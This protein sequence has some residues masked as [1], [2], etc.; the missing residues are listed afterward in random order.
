MIEKERALQILEAGLITS[1]ADQTE[2]V[3]MGEDFT[4]T[5]FAE[6]TI[7]QNMYRSD[8]TL[9]VRAVKGRKI[10]VSSTGDL[11]PSAVKQAVADAGAIADLMPEDPDFESLPQP[12]GAET[13]GDAVCFVPATA[14]SL[15]EQR[16]EAVKSIVGI[17][18]KLKL[19]CAG[20]FRVTT[21]TVAVLNSLGIRQ[22][23][24]STK[25]EL[26]LTAVGDQQNSGW[27]IGYS[28]DIDKIDAVALAEIAANKAARSRDPIAL[29]SG[30]YTVILEPAAVGQLLLFLAFMGFGGKTL[31]QQ[32]SFM[33]GKIG[34]K[35][36]G[37]NITIL[38]DPFDPKLAAVPFDYEGV[39][40]RQVMLIEKGVARGVVTNSYY[41]RLLDL[42]STG[43][44][45]P[46]NNTYG[47]YPKHM[48]VAPG[49]TSLEEMVA[50]TTRGVYITHF[51]YVNFLNPMKTQITGTT[52]DG[53]FLIENGKVTRA[54]RNMRL[55]QSI[56]DAFANAEMISSTRVLYPQYS[57]V[58]LVPA[59][60]INN[61][62]L[63]TTEG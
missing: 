3:L 10:G 58:M 5:R 17:V 26:S 40:R 25:A 29:E 46:P 48:A 31:Q 18:S 4:L 54:V 51:W 19:Q 9:F 11:S 7:H 63:E 37:D 42:E 32:R 28:R 53:T 39:P 60:K 24:A 62:N 15:P 47:P 61:F 41:A 57:V 6:S 1:S 50:A 14:A 36:T 38:E 20:A 2:L 49:D 27:A 21:E 22:Y 16:A 23:N 8:S 35:I 13:M 33:A 55:N 12:M 34:E 59:M 43:H 56:L 44:A 52:R 30:A 45:L